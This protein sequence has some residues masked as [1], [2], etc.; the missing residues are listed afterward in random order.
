MAELRKNDRLV[1]SGEET[2]YAGDTATLS[3]ALGPS[4]ENTVI[5]SLIKALTGPEP[6]PYEE[7]QRREMPPLPA[8]SIQR[9]PP[10]ATWRR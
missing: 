1:P 6:Q 9:T 2:F 8:G 4:K 5:D 3:E 7:W 10:P